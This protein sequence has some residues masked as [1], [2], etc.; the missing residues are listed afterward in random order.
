MLL[1]HTQ[2]TLHACPTYFLKKLQHGVDLQTAGTVI[3][4]VNHWKP[5]LLQAAPGSAVIAVKLK[6]QRK[7]N[8]FASAVE[9]NWPENGLKVPPSV[10]KVAPRWLRARIHAR[11]ARLQT[12]DLKPR[13]ISRQHRF[14]SAVKPGWRLP[15]SIA[16]LV[17]NS[18]TNMRLNKLSQDRLL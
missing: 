11:T 6:S 15:P 3:N 1:T 4:S 10:L 12:S 13:L 9:T 16:F 17:G 18:P 14:A 7:R 2:R 5:A 8:H